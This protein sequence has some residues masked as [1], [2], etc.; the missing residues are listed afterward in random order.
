MSPVAGLLG[1]VVDTVILNPRDACLASKA[2]CRPVTSEI[3]CECAAGG[4]GGKM[5]PA[6]NSWSCPPTKTTGLR[7]AMVA[8]YASTTGVLRS[9]FTAVADT[10]TPI[11]C[12]TLPDALGTVAAPVPAVV[13]RYTAPGVCPVTCV[14]VPSK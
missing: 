6:P 1:S 4:W 12:T 3:A 14:F 11:C 10:A 9:K 2:A 13:C 5:S 8:P 7:S